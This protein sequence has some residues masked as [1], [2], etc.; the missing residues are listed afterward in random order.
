MFEIASVAE[1]NHKSQRVLLKGGLRDSFDAEAIRDFLSQYYFERINKRPYWVFLFDRAE[2]F[3]E[4]WGFTV[5]RFEIR[6]DET[7]YTIEVRDRSECERPSD[8]DLAVYDTWRTLVR[9]DGQITDHN[10]REESMYSSSVEHSRKRMALAGGK[11][12]LDFEATD[13]AIMRCQMFLTLPALKRF[14]AE[15]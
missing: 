15:I 4:P 7:A 12:G 11:H 14:E 6:P 2:D 13:E 9:R 5:A 3:Q 8:L 10:N 1:E